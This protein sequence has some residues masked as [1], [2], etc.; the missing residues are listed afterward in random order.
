MM[1][2]AALRREDSF[3]YL[4]IRIVEIAFCSIFINYVVYIAEYEA[5]LN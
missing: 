2:F 1:S 3:F 5:I 4:S